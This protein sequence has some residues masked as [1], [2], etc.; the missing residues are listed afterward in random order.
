MLSLSIS[1]ILSNSWFWLA[2]VAVGIT[3]N[4]FWGKSPPPP[5]KSAFFEKHKKGIT[6]TIDVFLILV[7]F[8]GWAPLIYMAISML[9]KPLLNSPYAPISIKEELKYTLSFFSTGAIY[10]SEISGT[11]FGL[12]HIFQTNLN[13]LKRLTLLAIS[14]LPIVFTS[15][16]LIT[17]PVKESDYTWSVIKSGL[18]SFFGCLLVNG[19]AIIMGKHS[20]R[21]GWDIMRKLRWV[22]GDY[23]G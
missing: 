15:L 10:A 16:L 2:I 22:S 18:G 4:Y 19:P 13:K 23:P 20:L 7:I 5:R 21:V 3:V 14:L 11:L 8:F 17:T 1:K 9:P 12:L 6:R